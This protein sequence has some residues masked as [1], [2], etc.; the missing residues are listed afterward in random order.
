MYGANL[1]AILPILLFFFT[2][3]NIHTYYFIKKKKKVFK[4]KILVFKK[5]FSLVFVVIGSLLAPGAFTTLG[6]YGSM[7][8]CRTGSYVITYKSCNNRSMWR[9]VDRELEVVDNIREAGGKLNCIVNMN[10]LE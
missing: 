9:S 10:T 8:L 2:I 1:K 3:E 5:Y 7:R 6:L 4:K